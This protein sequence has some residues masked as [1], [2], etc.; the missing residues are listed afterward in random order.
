VITLR[1]LIARVRGTR[2]QRGF[3]WLVDLVRDFRLA[4][5][6]IRRSPAFSLTAILTL[7]IGIAANA[8]VFAVV[9]TV[10][11]T[12]LPYREPDTLVTVAESDTHTPNADRVSAATVRDLL[13]RTHSFE[14]L[15]LFGDYGVRP[16]L[17]NRVEQL[18]GMRVSTEFF[19]T[20]GVPM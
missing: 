15:S 20:L 5:R 10:L 14:R 9:K 12:P 16:I 7:A 3:P 8:V 17:G 6:T 2:D 1:D 18:R 4:A 11:L 19:E 13:D